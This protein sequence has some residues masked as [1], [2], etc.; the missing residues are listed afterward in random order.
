M[1]REQKSTVAVLIFGA[2][3]TVLNMTLINPALPSIMAEMGVSATTAQW[4]VSGFTLVNAMVIAISAFLMDKYPTRKLFLAIFTLFFAGSLLAAWS[5]SFAVL[6]AGRILQAMCA[7]VLLPMSITVLLLV[8]PHDKRGSAMG[9]FNLVIMFAPAIGPA[10][11]GLL[12]DQIGWRVM[13]LLMA[14]LGVIIIIIAFFTV[15]NFGE[16]KGATLDKPSLILS[17]IGLFCLLYGFS[18]F[19]QTLPLAV[20]LIAAGAAA[21]V[22]FARRQ[23]KLEHPFLE[24]SVLG[25]QQYRSGVI[26][27]MLIQA[28]LATGII[29]PIYVQ[30]VRGYSAA[31]SGLVMM[32][33]A[34]LGAIAGYFAGRLHDRFGA[35]D[36]AA[37]G[38]LLMVLSSV[39]IA[40]F[41][42][43]TS[44][45]FMIACYAVQMIGLMLASTPINLWSIGNLPDDILNHGNAVSS[46]LRQ[47]SSTLATA[48]LVSMMSLV[49]AG[50]GALEA[51]MSGIRVAYLLGIGIALAAFVLVFINVRDVKKAA[52][53]EEDTA[54]ELDVAMKQEVYTVSAHD[55]I[56]QVVEKLIEYR[57]SGL[58]VVDGTNHIVGFVSDGDVLRYMAR[59]DVRFGAEPYWV[60]LPDTESFT[61]KAKSLLQENVMLIATKKL[62]SVDRN[63]SLPEVCR[64]FYERR[65]HKLPV[66]QN[67]VLVGTISR[68][69]VMRILM[70]RL[71]L[72]GDT[73]L[74]MAAYNVKGS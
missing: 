35:R 42:F 54:F 13:F 9:L 36:L 48:I 37:L 45:A 52:A 20:G 55:C 23:L 25:A 74:D 29:L 22:F 2:F 71:P 28:S 18:I 63:T 12:T 59:Q 72:S 70:K 51:Q 27:Q 40:A 11:S 33:G 39:G 6:L 32:P 43:G 50:R 68:G 3:L 7:G 16:I 31:V 73:Y 10:I 41:G 65:L 44:V 34:V 5:P 57:T 26:I 69:D 14:L 58:P 49:T 62:I 8:F 15:R 56:K 30:T 19:G 24:I 64:L 4:L 46:A 53:F 60:I 61:D 38:A 21:L 17:S 67:G 47:T 1:T 66:T